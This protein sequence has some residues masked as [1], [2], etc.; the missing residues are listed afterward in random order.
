MFDNITFEVLRMLYY[1]VIRTK[2]NGKENSD[3]SLTR[4]KGTDDYL[5]LHFK[6]PVIFTLSGNEHRISPGTCILLSPGTPHSFKPYNSELLHDWIHFLPSDFNE[7]SDLKIDINTFFTVYNPD[8]ITTSVIKCE[9]ELIWKNAF[10]EDLISSE[11]SRML[12]KIKRQLDKNVL[13]YHSDK[14][15]DLRVSV[16]RNPK[17]YLSTDDMASYVG[18]SRS[19]FSVLY[20]D[21]FGVSPKNDLINARIEK[22]SYL[23]SIDSPTLLDISEE[24]GYQSIYHFIR[25]FKTVTGTTPGKY[26]KNH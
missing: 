8:F 25:Q 15:K 26:R 6:S 14:F 20:K 23:L 19:R 13:G 18:L 7:F 3:F 12:I 21:F 2:H 1:T 10:Y 17:K 16:Y 9:Q 5:F 4:P 11:V 22:A 24:C